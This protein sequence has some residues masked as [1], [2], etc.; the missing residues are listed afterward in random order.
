MNNKKPK[1][2]KRKIK[3]KHSKISKIKKIKEIN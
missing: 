3:Y 2:N 1:Q